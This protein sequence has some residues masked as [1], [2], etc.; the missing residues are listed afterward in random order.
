MEEDLVRVRAFIDSH[1][2]HFAK[3]MQLRFFFKC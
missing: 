3:T 1:E 2:R